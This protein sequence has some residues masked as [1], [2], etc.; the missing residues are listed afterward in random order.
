MNWKPIETAPKDG[1]KILAFKNGA[2]F[3]CYWCDFAGGWIRDTF[4]CGGITHWM[5]LPPDPCA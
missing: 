2:K 4:D 3:V 5:P 1:T